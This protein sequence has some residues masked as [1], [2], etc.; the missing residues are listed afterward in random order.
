M[1]TPAGPT[2]A[3]PLL[4]RVLAQL[5]PGAV[6]PTCL[7]TGG[8]GFVGS[9]L[10]EA[11][12][13]LGCQVVAVDT[14]R[15]PRAQ[16]P[17]VIHR[18]VDVCH[19]PALDELL[20][21]RPVDVVFHCAGAETTQGLLPPSAEHA[22]LRLHAVGTANVVG[23]ARRAGVSRLVAVGSARAAS[24]AGGAPA[25]DAYS[26]SKRYAERMV[27]SADH[28]GGLRTLVLH[29]AAVWGAGG[30]LVPAFLELLV[31]GR[32]DRWPAATGPTLPTTHLDSLVRALLL[33][34]ARLA[35]AADL[36]GGRALRIVDPEGL[37]PRAWFAPLLEELGYASPP[38]RRLPGPQRLRAWWGERVHQ[39]GGPPTPLTRPLLTLLGGTSPMAGEEA[40]TVLGWA[41]VVT[42]A[43]GTALL[44]P[45]LH[46]LHAQAWARQHA[47]PLPFRAPDAALCH[48][49]VPK[50]VFVVWDRAE[51]DRAARERRLLEGVGPRL[52]AE[53]DLA[54]LAIDLDGPH[55]RVPAPSPLPLGARPVAGLITLRTATPDA[56]E[57]V[58]R[59][60]SQSGFD[61]AGYRVEASVYRDYGDNDHSG[62]RDWPDGTRSPGVVL[63][64]L[65]EKPRMM[66]YD[67][68]LRGWFEGI[69]PISEAIQP[70]TRYV[71]NRVL[72]PVTPGA[73]P[74]AGIVEEGFPSA[75]HVRNPRLFYGAASTFELVRNI[76]RILWTVTRFLSLSR[77][78]TTVMSETFLVT[79][80]WTGGPL[81]PEEVPRAADLPE[82][83]E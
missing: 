79:P 48:E 23:A 56:P 30:A 21:F 50:L 9:R 13:A 14:A 59:V 18:K 39:R 81:E 10:V 37:E 76:A 17:R 53:L 60:L 2:R 38:R 51:R 61:C 46:P 1:P 49:A 82:G 72:E 36:V 15:T 31:S 41:P 6:G 73:P 42:H 24:A 28:T 35:E 45:A 11:L 29:P 43:E 33:G 70:R 16:T 19:R 66:A 7:V 68:W 22:L 26:R 80:G 44:A 3:D 47:P 64:A 77:I 75:Q 34:A 74:L 5:D 52:R 62:P 20:A 12:A 63:V 58:S 54:S 4:Q 8:R 32:L 40:R 55:S 67:D 27:R 65:F 57:Q 25:D 71:R 78:Q 69:S 83:E